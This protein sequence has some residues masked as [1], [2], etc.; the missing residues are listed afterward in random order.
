MGSLLDEMKRIT[1]RF[2]RE[3]T[4]REPVKDRLLG[5]EGKAGQDH[6]IDLAL[7]RWKNYRERKRIP[8][9][10]AKIS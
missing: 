7:K 6:E 4:G 3:M 2:Y 8:A 9:R 10:K 5:H 1:A